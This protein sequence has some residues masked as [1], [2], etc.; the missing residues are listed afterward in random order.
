MGD[1]DNVQKHPQ[2]LAADFSAGSL[3][4]WKRRRMIFKDTERYKMSPE[5]TLSR[6]IYHSDIR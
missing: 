2:S 5:N 1:D 4:A 6:N 3:Q